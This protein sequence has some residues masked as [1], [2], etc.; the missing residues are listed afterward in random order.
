MKE[1]VKVTFEERL[2][3]DKE[4]TAL[5][6]ITQVIKYYG[7]DLI[8]TERIL[9]YLLSRIQNDQRSVAIVDQSKR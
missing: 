8:E 3:N 1:P 7:L 2:T 6:I 5:D 9:Q 4:L